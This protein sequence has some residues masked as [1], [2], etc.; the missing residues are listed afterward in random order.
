[1]RHEIQ[2]NNNTAVSVEAGTWWFDNMTLYINI[3]KGIQDSL[4]QKIVDRLEED[5][6]TF[7]SQLTVSIILMVVSL[8]LTPVIV[9]GVHRMTSKIHRFAHNLR[10]K[11]LD[12][13]KE[14]K[15]T[16]GLLNQMLPASV[17]RSLVSK[18]SV[19]PES[20]EA[21]TIFFSDIVSFTAISSKCTPLEVVRLLSY[22]YEAFDDR[23]E[24]YDVYKV[25]TI[26]DGYMVASGLPQKNGDRHAAEIASLSLDVMETISDLVIPIIPG[27]KLKLRVGI[28][29][30]P[31]VAGIVGNKMPRYCLFGDTVNTASR[32]ESSS[33]PMKIQISTST[34]EYLDK[35]GGFSVS[36]RG[37]I[38]IKGK[39]IMQT[40]WLLGKHTG[41]GKREVVD[42]TS[43]NLHS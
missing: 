7:Q 16:E 43:S 35:C 29:S 12:L 33:E 24:L 17:A 4:A 39:G 15:K 1:M 23:L 22:L 2:E 34:K 32:M 13:E 40:F 38:S 36:E 25:E 10:T 9:L 11:T 18:Q 8:V 5:V 37:L 31:V 41:P 26:G 42:L 6:A 21:V 20:F 28:N 30:G 14:R 27:E 19:P 3:L